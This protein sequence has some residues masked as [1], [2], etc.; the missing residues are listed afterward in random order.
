MNR[1]RFA[2]IQSNKDSVV[3]YM[4]QNGFEATHGNLHGVEPAEVFN[5][6]VLEVAAHQLRTALEQ[7][8][9]GNRKYVWQRI[10][11]DG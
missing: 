11:E 6:R 5:D 1:P 4:N 9:K 2:E 10:E 8:S 3:L 7:E